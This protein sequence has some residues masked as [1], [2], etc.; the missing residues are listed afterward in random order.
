M[1][2]KFQS[3]RRLG[4][5]NCSSAHPATVGKTTLNATFANFGLIWIK[6]DVKNGESKMESSVFEGAGMV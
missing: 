5:F 2:K 1:E 3:F 6:L 4:G